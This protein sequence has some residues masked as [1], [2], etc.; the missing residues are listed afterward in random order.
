[1]LQKKK[2]EKSA[3]TLICTYIH[4]VFFLFFFFFNYI[5]GTPEM[6]FVNYKAKP[7]TFKWRKFELHF[8]NMNLEC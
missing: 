7:S 5:C 3:W 8:F 1:M 6:I 4:F 2:R